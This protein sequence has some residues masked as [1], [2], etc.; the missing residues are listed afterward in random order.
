MITLF[1]RYLIKIFSSK[2][3]YNA[4]LKSLEL[5]DY[6][7]EYL[8][9]SKLIGNNYYVYYRRKCSDDLYERLII[10]FYWHSDATSFKTEYTTFRELKLREYCH[11]I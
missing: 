2:K 8:P 3:Y 5:E 6:D 10:P 7:I 1:G 4:Y 11:V 9:N